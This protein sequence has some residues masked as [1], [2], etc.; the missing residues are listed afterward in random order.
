MPKIDLD[1]LEWKHGSSYPGGYA[2]MVGDR[3]QKRLGDPAGLT[4][5]GANLVR[6]GPGALSSLRHWH[7]L[8]DEF[9]V[10]TQGALVLVDDA[11]E[12]PLAPGDC[13]AFPAGDANGHHIVNRSDSDGAFVVVGTRTA[14]EVGW[15]SD[16]DMKVTAQD[17]QMRFTRRD[18]SALGAGS[19]IPDPD[20]AGISER[21]TRALLAGDTQGFADLCSLP[22]TVMPRT[23]KPYMLHTT[24]DMAED[25]RLYHR[26]LSSN[27]VTDIFRVQKSITRP[28]P[29]QAEILVEV[30]LMAGAQRIVGP[31]D[32][33]FSLVWTG[34]DW[35]VARIESAL[36]HINWTLGR[37]GLPDSGRFEGT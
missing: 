3:S 13:C 26:S 21:M 15:Y 5:F 28:M 17:G 34:A 36:G 2:A 25:T 31:Y 9:L 27:H 16:V 24:E 8:Q 10:V 30:H 12:T 1:A 7:E 23:G 33:T 22:Q 20:F 18:G 6:L 11:G 37:T 35:R 4:Q 14:T 32:I 19:A 29:E